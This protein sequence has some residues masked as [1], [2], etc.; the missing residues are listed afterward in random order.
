MMNELGYWLGKPF[1]GQGIMPEAARE[2][3]RHGFEDIGMTKICA[4]TMK[5]IRSQSASRRR[6]DFAISGNRKM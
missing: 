6:R 4:D 1:W 5:A 3:I 2:V